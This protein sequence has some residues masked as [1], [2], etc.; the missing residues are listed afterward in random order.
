[1]KRIF[2]PILTLISLLI[3]GLLLLT[4]LSARINP[5]HANILAF[6]GFGFPIIWI[7]NLLVL[8]FWISRLRMQFLIP[9]LALL[10]TWNNWHNT[11]QISGR[12]IT[13]STQ[14]SNPVSVMSFNVKMLD[15]Y[16]WTGEKEVHDKIFKFI[17]KENPDILCIQ[18]FFSYKGKEGFSEAQ[19]LARLN[20]YPY[21]HI[22]Y[23]VK[24]NRGRR[25]GLATFSRYPIKGKRYLKFEQTNNFSMQTDI[26]VNNTKIRVFNNHLES[27]RFDAHNLNFIDSLNYKNEAERRKGISEIAA[28]LRAAFKQRA[29]QA[30]TIGSH[31]GNSPYPVIVC[32][33]FNDTPVSYVYRKMRGDLK[34]AFVESGS[35]FG[36]TYN[37]K[38]PSFRIDFIFHDPQ[39]NSYNFTRTK[40]NYSDH[41][42]IMTTIDLETESNS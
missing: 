20:Q 37:G 15:F 30:E 1:M 42:P 8:V 12:H 11:F 29:S 31:I 24:G 7:I 14:I 38:L 18:E 33:D 40:V 23:S 9:L 35:G 39:F 32:G 22:E 34:D 26:E 13:E 36:G 16:K 10:F 17:R 4:V 25:F 27:I 21:R 3:A 5:Y 19:I 6:L 2:R 28:K 41:F